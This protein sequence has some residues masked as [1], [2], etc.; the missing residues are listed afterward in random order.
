[1][2]KPIIHKIG[3]G[4]SVPALNSNARSRCGLVGVVTAREQPFSHLLTEAGSN[5][6]ATTRNDLITCLKCKNL[7]AIGT[8]HAKRS[9]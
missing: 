1:M 5:F 9:R 4:P 8:I 6:K 2:A 3:E 7:L